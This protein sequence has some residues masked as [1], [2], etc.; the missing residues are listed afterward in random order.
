MSKLDA[1]RVWVDGC[2]DFTHYGHARAILQARRTIPLSD[3]ASCLICG[4]H[5]D[6]DIEFNK[7]AKPVMSQEERYGHIRANRWIHTVVENAPYVTQPEVL[8]SH[9]CL[10]VVHGDDIST[11]SNGYDCYQKMKDVGRFKVVD[12]TAGVSTTDIIH[13]ILTGT[14]SP[15]ESPL[16]DIAALKLFATSEDGFSPWA[17]VFD[18]TIDNVVVE[19]GY[20]WDPS[21]VVYVQHSFDLLHIGQIDRLRQL[22][23]LSGNK[24]L[25]VGITNTSDNDAAASNNNVAQLYMSSKERVLGVLSCRYVDAI[26]INPR[27]TFKINTSN[28]EHWELADPRL[29]DTPFNYLNKQTIVDRILQNKDYYVARN[30]RK[31]MDPQNP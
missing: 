17:W 2:F 10:Y 4:V 15:E 29:D 1:R 25:L 23:K 6:R 11:D 30:I 16:K 20:Q 13:R 24:K 27:H 9:G 12:R 22:K 31:G 7:H 21:N 18:S 19:G 26:I 14:A 28:M 3:L 8:D 5:N